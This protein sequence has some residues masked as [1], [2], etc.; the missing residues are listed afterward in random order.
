MNNKD[1]VYKVVSTLL[2][3][4]DYYG[5]DLF[6]REDEGVVSV[7]VNCNDIFYWATAD[8]EEIET[9]EQIHEIERAFKDLAAIGEVESVV[10]G[11][12]LWCC[13]KRQM[14]PQKPVLETIP[15]KIRHMFEQC[16]P[17]REE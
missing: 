17:E 13:R 7:F 3:N 2:T 15:E 4:D 8:C 12:E 6:W 5:C 1:F 9:P 16:G 14:R 10:W 11:A